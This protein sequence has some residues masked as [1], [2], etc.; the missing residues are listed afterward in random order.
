MMAFEKQGRWLSAVETEWWRSKKKLNP[1]D[2]FTKCQFRFAAKRVSRLFANCGTKTVT[3]E[4]NPISMNGFSAS[5][6]GVDM[7][8]P[9]LIVSPEREN[10]IIG[11]LRRCFHLQEDLHSSQ[12]FAFIF[13]HVCD[14]NSTT[15]NPI[16]KQPFPNTSNVVFHINDHRFTL[17]FSPENLSHLN[18]RL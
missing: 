9:I 5:G 8:R 1:R 12:R 18:H 7:E 6:G 16:T 15:L 4:T 11:L 14:K 17:D 2:N 3:T 10:E 13:R